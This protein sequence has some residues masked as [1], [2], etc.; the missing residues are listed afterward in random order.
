MMATKIVLFSP[1]VDFLGAGTSSSSSPSSRMGPC[2]LPN[3]H[4]DDER[5]GWVTV[6]GGLAGRSGPQ[7]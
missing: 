4:Q 2:F 6:L 7:K 3:G 5:G 1:G